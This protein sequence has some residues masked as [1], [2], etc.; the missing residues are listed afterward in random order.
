MRRS[1]LGALV[2]A[3]VATA[4]PGLGQTAQVALGP[5][6]QDT[7]LPVEITADQLTVDQKDGSA[8][9]L[10]NVL[11]GQGT[12][13]LSAGAVR[14][15]Y[16]TDDDATPGKIEKLIATEGVTLV[17]EGE[18][19]ESRDAEYT[20]DTGKIVMTGDVILTQGDNALS[21][22]RLVVDLKTGTGQMDGRVKTII[23]PGKK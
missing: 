8:T 5:L 10:G 6:K 4:G 22:Q 18:A 15:E 14:V 16:A 13:R 12:M 11:I 7:S 3:V 1:L 23:L 17:T 2:V 9:F 21:S 19:A 20:I